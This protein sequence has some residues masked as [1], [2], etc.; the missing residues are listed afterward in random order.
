MA[1]NPD[2]VDQRLEI[3]FCQRSGLSRMET[4]TRLR[5]MH[6]HGT[7]SDATIRRWFNKF[8]A[9]ENRISDLPRPGAP[10]L[11][12]P[13]KIRQ[14]RQLL[15][16]DKR[17]SVASLACQTQLSVGTTH[18][19]LRK[20]LQVTKRPAKWV[21]HLLTQPQKDRRVAMCR[22]SLARLRHG[23][24]VDHIICGDESWFHLWDPASKEA[25]KVWLQRNE[26]RP[27]VV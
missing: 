21:P 4:I 17:Q 12:M 5:A 24:D 16:A 22:Q 25:N 19:L 6:G 27:T 2:K 1:P 9:G 8:E 13:T 3:R 15:D 20:D 7:L 11:R 23:G 10:T 14:V 26:E 18:K